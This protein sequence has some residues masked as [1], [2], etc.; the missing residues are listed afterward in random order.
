M[1][2]V[3]VSGVVGRNRSRDMTPE[4]TVVVIYKQSKL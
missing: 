3:A 4:A 2:M 1:V